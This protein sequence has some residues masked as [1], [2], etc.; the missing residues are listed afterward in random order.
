M[1]RRHTQKASHAQRRERLNRE[2]GHDPFNGDTEALK[3]ELERRLKRHADILGYD[4]LCRRL[5]ARGLE[6][7]PVD[8]SRLPNAQPSAPASSAPAQSPQEPS[9]PE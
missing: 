1:P 3:A 7:P 9:A 8:E 4:E 5:R 2:R 6:P